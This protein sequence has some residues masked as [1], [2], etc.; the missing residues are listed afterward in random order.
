[1]VEDHD[2]AKSALLIPNN[3]RHNRL[4][5]VESAAGRQCL[6]RKSHHLWV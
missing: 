5:F 4:Y 3:R 1:M 2:E 6:S